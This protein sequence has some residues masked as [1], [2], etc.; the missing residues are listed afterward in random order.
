MCLSLED[1]AFMY[2]QMALYASRKRKYSDAF[3]WIDIA[4]NCEKRNIFS[5]RNTHAIILFNANI[6]QENID[7]SVISTLHHSLEI[8]QDCYKNDLRKGFHARIFGELVIKFYNAYGYD[9]VEKYVD[10]AYEWLEKE[11]ESKNNGS[12]SIKKMRQIK[13]SIEKEI[14]LPNQ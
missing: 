8:L 4:K 13:K 9:E 12:S 3:K 7:G 1:S 6:Q 5:I 11:I 14:I 10:T 2:Q